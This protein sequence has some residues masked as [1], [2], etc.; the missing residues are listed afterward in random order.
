MIL[1]TFFRNHF[2]F[3]PFAQTKTNHFLFVLANFL[4]RSVN[5]SPQANIDALR[6]YGGNADPFHF[7]PQLVENIVENHYEE[8]KKTHD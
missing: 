3:L 4:T 8:R 5:R 6:P 2:H 1:S 7:F